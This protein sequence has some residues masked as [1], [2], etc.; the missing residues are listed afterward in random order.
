MRIPSFLSVVA[1]VSAVK[2][3]WQWIKIYELKLHSLLKPNEN[4]WVLKL[5][6]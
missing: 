1:G 5:P 4:A 2:Q 3:R 6:R